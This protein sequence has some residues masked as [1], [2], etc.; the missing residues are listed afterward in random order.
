MDNKNFWEKRAMKYGHTGWWDPL[1]YAFDQKIRIS[2]VKELISTIK[3]ENEK[4]ILDFGGG[5][6]DFLFNLQEVFRKGVLYDPCENVLS[7]AKERIGQNIT[8]YS[9]LELMRKQEKINYDIILSIT[10]LQHIMKDEEL[11]SVLQF[12]YDSLEDKGRFIV[13]ETFDKSVHSTYERSW[14]YN[15]FS[16]MI[17]EV[18]F[19]VVNAYDYYSPL[20]D[21]NKKF[22]AFASRVDVKILAMLAKTVK[23]NTNKSLQKIALEYNSDISDFLFEFSNQPGSK[24]LVLAK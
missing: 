7:I 22:K 5:T 11:K 20:K 6:G 13:M 16:Y 1:I 24:F 9:D 12:L 8:C 19:R 3:D 21:N 18:G 23:F 15:E 10:V 14:N 17:N 2:V 4:T